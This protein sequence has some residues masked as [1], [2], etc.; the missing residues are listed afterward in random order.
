MV[1]KLTTG[2]RVRI[3][4]N[5]GRGEKGTIVQLSP[6]TVSGNEVPTYCKILGD[7]GIFYFVKEAWL[8]RLKHGY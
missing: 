8:R 4:T 6:V 2:M 1:V 7:D 5:K 3:Y